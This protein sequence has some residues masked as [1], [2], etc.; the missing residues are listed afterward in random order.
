[1]TELKI[2]NMNDVEI[3]EIEWLWQDFIPYKKLTIV[4]GDSGE[5]KTTALLQIIG[6]LTTGREIISAPG[7]PAVREPINV[8]YQTAEDGLGDTIK[9]RLVAAGADCSR[10][11]VI[12]DSEKA[13]T[14]S[15][16]RLEEAIIQTGAKL[17]VLDP[18]QAY[19]GANVDMHRANEVRPI[20]SRVGTLADKYGC[21]IVLIGHLNKSIL[22]K[23]GYRGL[24]SVDFGAAARSVI[25]C[26]RIKD[27]PDVRVLAIQKASLA[28]E[29][30][31]VAFRL[32]KEHGF[33]W[34]GEYDI[35]VDELL[36]GST[37]GEKTNVAKEFL[38]EKLEDGM[39]PS[40]DLYDEAMA[41][42]IK[43]KTLRNAMKELNTRA[44]KDGD[45]WYTA[46]PAD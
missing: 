36:T 25:V 32:S 4:Q 40:S 10:V 17:V 3:E 27:D 5:G 30:T 35:T 7:S 44:I 38:L 8:I 16:E 11:L 34:I 21:A 13:L 22:M 15:D 33:E 39:M 12:D 2:I 6:S 43:K 23:A 18:I 46:L 24:G 42:G 29:A 20:L 31:P 19:L 41:Q 45:K 9:P 14:M 26:G 1:M 37:R 28:Y